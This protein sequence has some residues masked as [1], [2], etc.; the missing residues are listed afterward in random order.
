MKD[1]RVAGVG[2]QARSENKEGVE[3]LGFCVVIAV[4]LDFEHSLLLVVWGTPTNS[5]GHST[6]PNYYM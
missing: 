6:C 4:V 1:N 3:D 2:G 5:N